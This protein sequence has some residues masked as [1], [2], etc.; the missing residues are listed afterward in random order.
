MG[1][2]SQ[3]ADKLTLSEVSTDM[4]IFRREAEKNSLF[5]EIFPSYDMEPI[6]VKMAISSVTCSNME[7][8]HANSSLEIDEIRRLFREY[9][10]FLDVDL[11]FQQFESELESLPGKYAPPKGVLLLA[12][13]G[14]EALGC[15]ALRRFGPILEHSCEM[16]RLYVR[17]IP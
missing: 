5:F 6:I 2:K 10:S 16:K 12:S 7:I 1:T 8:V 13:N 15:G 3:W 9:E 14:Q 4:D 11:S 17:D